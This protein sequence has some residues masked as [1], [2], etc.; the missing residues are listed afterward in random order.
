LIEDFDVSISMPT[1]LLSD[2][3]YAI[4]ITRDSVKHELN[5]YIDVDAYFTRSQI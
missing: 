5:K 3:T 4:S 2:G 1:P